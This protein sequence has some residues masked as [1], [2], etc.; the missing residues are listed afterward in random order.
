[1]SPEVCE[2]DLTWCLAEQPIKIVRL[3]EGLKFFHASKI[4]SYDE[5]GGG[6]GLAAESSLAPQK[7]FLKETSFALFPL[8]VCL[9][10]SVTNTQSR[11]HSFKIIKPYMQ[12][13]SQN[14]NRLIFL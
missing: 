1:M 12:V 9:S 6:G 7:V 13:L 5:R 14:I 4:T 11:M 10:V 2:L 3:G 8:P